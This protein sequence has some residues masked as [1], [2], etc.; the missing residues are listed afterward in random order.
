MIDKYIDDLRPNR[1]VEPLSKALVVRKAGK[2]LK[3]SVK[4]YK[5]SKKV[6]KIP[7]YSINKIK[8]YTLYTYSGNKERFILDSGA[9]I[10][11]TYIKN[12]LTDYKTINKTVKWGN[13]G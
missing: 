5:T 2:Y 7:V 13:A 1:P 8:N 12:N 11:T 10:H 6:D 4:S 3:K 9:I